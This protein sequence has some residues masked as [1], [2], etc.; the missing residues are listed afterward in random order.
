MRILFYIFLTCLV[1]GLFEY[2]FPW[3]TLALATFLVTLF[4]R[5]SPGR[6][7]LLAFLSVS[8]LWLF[9]GGLRDFNNGHILATR[10]A[11]LFG[12]NGFYFL[13]LIVS[14]I[15]GGIVAGFSALSC[16]IL[17]RRFNS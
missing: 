11:G 13:F 4:F 10:L 16:V 14:S 15:V 12:M 17:K 5:F 8:L 3:W 7:F 2:F 1:A 6:A 9:I